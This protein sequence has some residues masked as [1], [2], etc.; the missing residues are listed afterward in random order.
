MSEGELTYIKV[1]LCTC[2]FEMEAGKVRFPLHKELHSAD[3]EI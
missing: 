1:F 2:F 3:L